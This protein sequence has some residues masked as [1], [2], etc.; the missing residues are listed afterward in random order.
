MALTEIDFK[1]V[2]L[3]GSLSQKDIHRSLLDSDII[4]L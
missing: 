3:Y 4:V 1:I 2:Y